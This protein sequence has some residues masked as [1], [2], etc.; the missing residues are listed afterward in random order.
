MCYLIE[1]EKPTP[2]PKADTPYKEGIYFDMPEKEYFAIPYFSRSG[3]EKILFSAEQYWEDSP[4]NPDYKPTKVTPAMELGKAIHCQLL[5]PERFAK[6]YAKKPALSDF[7]GKNILRTSEDIKVFLTSIGEKKTG[8]KEDLIA[9]ADEYLDHKKEII[10]DVIIDNFNAD[11]AATG[12]RILTEF[13]IEILDGIKTAF[14]RRQIMPELLRNTRS[15]IVII[16]KDADTGIMCK[17]MIDAARPEAIGEIK[18]F[19]VKNFNIPI[20]TT[21][22]KEINHR[23]YNHQY[24]IYSLALKTVIDKIN[25]GTAKVYGEVDSVWIDSF[26]KTPDKQ[27]FLM[28]FRTQAPYQC[29]PYELEKAITKGATANVY[30]EQAAILWNA[31]L[32]KLQYC[33]TTFGISRWIDDD[34]VIVLADEHMPSIL[35]QTSGI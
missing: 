20:E 8:K 5:E 2:K 21:M 33:Y 12:K 30:F 15:E 18:S 24:Y 9:R 23:H 6:L 19:S 17:C 11:V 27:F 35:Y 29:R 10:W 16:W 3:A 14:K 22:L 28:F 13:D 32:T 1:K 31:A 25:R 7:D 26:L 4:M 34:E